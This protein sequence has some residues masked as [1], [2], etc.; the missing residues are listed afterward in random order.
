MLSFVHC[1]K[2]INEFKLGLQ[3]GNAQFRS[4]SVGFFVPCEPQ[5]WRMTSK[6]NRESLLCYF[7]HCVWFHSICEF[8]LEL[9]SGNAEFRLK[10]ANFVRFDL[11][12]WPWKTIWHL[13]YAAVSFV[14]HFIAIGGFNLSYSP[15]PPNSGQNLW[16]FVP[17]NLEIRQMT[18]KSN[19]APPP[20]HGKPCASFRSHV[21]IKSGVTVRKPPNWDKICF[22]PSDLEF[23]LWTL[24][25]WTNL[26]SVNA[27][28]S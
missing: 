16:L 15:E 25:F 28:N 19:R 22:D 8:K 18:S 21:W 20:C 12:V 11:K 13:F 2:A 1:F 6:N 4:N 10:S 14:H 3:S 27:K 9:Q 7:K 5:I 26:S 24:T 17:C 23:L